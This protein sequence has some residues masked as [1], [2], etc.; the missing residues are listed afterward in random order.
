MDEYATLG[1]WL[2]VSWMGP[3]FERARTGA[4][5]ETDIFRIA[6]DSRARLLA[7][8]FQSFMWVVLVIV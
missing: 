3:L 7:R 5:H 1:Q 8:K 6:T 4:L 2:T